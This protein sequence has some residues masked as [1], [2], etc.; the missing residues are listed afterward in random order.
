MRSSSPRVGYN[1]DH[2]DRAVD[3]DEG[4]IT[5]HLQVW[6]KII[7]IDKEKEDMKEA[8]LALLLLGRVSCQ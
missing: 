7:A 6:R 2:R 8:T 3:D 1:L 5:F 4:A